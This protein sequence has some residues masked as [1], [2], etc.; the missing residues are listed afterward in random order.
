MK[1]DTSTPEGKAKLEKLLIDAVLNQEPEMLEGNY[2][3]NKQ[4]L[5]DY[6]EA[7]SILAQWAREE[8]CSFTY[9]LWYKPYPLH[10]IYVRW[11]VD[12]DPYGLPEYSATEMA[13]LIRRFHTIQLDKQEPFTWQLS[14][15]I[16]V[17]EA[18]EKE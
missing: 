16:Y 17:D 15:E 5:D 10:C 9:D 1:I 13:D 6:M 11:N 12:V 18:S 7:L 8:K 3:V 4:A 2:N 14:S